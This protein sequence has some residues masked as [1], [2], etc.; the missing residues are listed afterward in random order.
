MKAEKIKIRV[1]KLGNVIVT[2]FI[3]GKKIIQTEIKYV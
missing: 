3:Q 2:Q 1:K